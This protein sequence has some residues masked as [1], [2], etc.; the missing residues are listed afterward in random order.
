M[1]TLEIC[2]DRLEKGK[3]SIVV[4]RDGVFLQV[5]NGCC[6]INLVIFVTVLL[7]TITAIYQFIFDVEGV[8]QY[9]LCEDISQ[10][11][12]RHTPVQDGRLNRQGRKKNHVEWDPVP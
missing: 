4:S 10:I 8:V 5:F 1:L 3:N 6:F 2:H 12:Q 9:F 11:Q 7:F